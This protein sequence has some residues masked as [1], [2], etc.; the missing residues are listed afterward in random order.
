MK[1]QIV[2]WR[3]VPADVEKGMTSQWGRVPA[4]VAERI[5]ITGQ[6]FFTVEKYPDLPKGI[7]Y[8]DRLRTMP[9]PQTESDFRPPEYPKILR[10]TMRDLEVLGAELTPDMSRQKQGIK[11]WLHEFMPEYCRG[12]EGYVVVDWSFYTGRPRSRGVQAE[13]EQV[14]RILESVFRKN[15]FGSLTNY[16]GCIAYPEP[17]NSE[18]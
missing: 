10:L 3:K 5:C 13:I 4:V 8:D 18:M 17:T 9:L 7:T 6:L 12:G 15:G 2:V 11:D 1:N 14:R 16:G